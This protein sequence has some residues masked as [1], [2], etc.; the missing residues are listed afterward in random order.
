MPTR[1]KSIG[2]TKKMYEEGEKSGSQDNIS[3]QSDTA[4]SQNRVA[5]WP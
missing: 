3:S 1:N 5:L 2:K 4:Q